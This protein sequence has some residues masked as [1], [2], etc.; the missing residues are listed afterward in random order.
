MT[1][2]FRNKKWCRSGYC[3]F[4]SAK[5]TVL[6]DEEWLKLEVSRMEIEKTN[7]MNALFEFYSTLLTENK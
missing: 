6:S 3:L 1:E 5:M 7:R 2:V 4:Y